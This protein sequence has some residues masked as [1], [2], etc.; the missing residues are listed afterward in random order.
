M[1]ASLSA[2]TTLES[3][4]LFQSLHAYGVASTVFS[5]ISDLLKRNP[6]VTDQKH[7]EAGRLSPDAIRAFYVDRLKREVELE[8]G[9]EHG[10][11]NSDTANPRKRKVASPKGSTVQ[12]LLQHQDLIPRLVEKLYATYRNE[13]TELIRAEEERH[14]RLQRE[15]QSIERGEWDE[16]LKERANAKA[17]ASR[18][19]TLSTR[20]PHAA[21][22]SL[23]SK[24]APQVAAQNATP[25]SIA[26]SPPSQQTHPQPL[27]P[28]PGFQ[29]FAQPPGAG[30]NGPPYAHLSPHPPGPQS[31]APQ[32]LPPQPGPHHSQSPVAGHPPGP[33]QHQ[34]IQPYGGN[35]VPQYGPPPGSSPQYPP[36]HQRLPHQQHL[37]AQSPGALPPQQQPRIYYPHPGQ[38]L[39][40][41]QQPPAL[42]PPPQAGFMLPPFQVSP[43]D[44]SRVHN[45][46][47]VPPHHPQASTPVSHRQQAPTSK[48]LAQTPGPY[49]PGV[50]SMHPLVTQARQSFST[51]TN[52]RSPHSAFGTP[53][54][55]KSQ[56]KRQNLVGTPVTPRPELEPIDD[57]LSLSASK[58]SAFKARSSRRSRTKGKAKAKEP[59]NVAEET[60]TQEASTQEANSAPATPQVI[61]PL[62]EPAPELNT[63]QG[64]SRRKA[65]AKRARP[66]SIASSRAGGSVRDRSRSQSILSHTETVA[67]DNESQ[68]GNPIKSERGTSVDAVEEEPVHTPSQMVTRRRGAARA[69]STTRRKRNAR[70]ASLEEPED[71]ISTPGP[72]R[73]IIAPR[74][75]SHMSNPIMNDIGSH[76]HA[77]LFSSA[78]RA[79]NAP[80]YYKIIKRPTDLKF[81]QKA[82]AAGAKQVAA[83]ASDT[84]V[85]SPGGAGGV[86]EL[87]MTSNTIPP[88]AIV[89]SSQLEKELM[90]MFVN[91]V[92]FNPG[93][94]G[95]VEDARQMFETV[96]RS[97]SNWR[98]VERSSGRTEVEDTPAAEEEEAPTASKRRKV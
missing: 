65:A 2:Y 47:T 46:P 91:A 92:M 87:P 71:Q 13:I 25:Q 36:V 32:N 38:P 19:P 79:N 86:V 74:R 40:P 48:T 77:S 75:F 37:S 22:K 33:F 53:V 82:I 66:G 88:T 6:D 28:P 5:T 90:R 15:L 21:Q 72:P 62:D 45:S 35:G 31:Q 76:R 34:P 59:D 58:A 49:R 12:E 27:V 44:P 68:T 56:W 4:L 89:N 57:F 61:E 9:A 29:Q 14:D 63:R 41:N 30:Y 52:S 55:A 1:S 70:E 16:Q 64:R 11:H 85:G 67:A 23:Q 43:Q 51:P 39:H 98:N 17:H 3:L 96:Q 80:D 95:V 97:V 94:E 7:Y 78:V 84:P 26:A 50:P 73:T 93:E 69:H 42:Q 81:I 54:S 83:A 10:G 18:S 8:Q 60:S 20:S 24:A